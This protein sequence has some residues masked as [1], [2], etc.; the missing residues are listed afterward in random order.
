MKDSHLDVCVYLRVVDNNDKNKLY[1]ITS[2]KNHNFVG[3]LYMLPVSIVH[4]YIV[5]NLFK[6]I[7]IDKS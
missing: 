2:V 3:K 7:N 5:T 1:L 6:N 4:P